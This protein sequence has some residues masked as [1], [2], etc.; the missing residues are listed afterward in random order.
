LGS[1]CSDPQALFI[2]D[3]SPLIGAGHITRCLALAR[4]LAIGG[5]HCHFAVSPNALRTVPA[6]NASGFSISVVEFQSTSLMRLCKRQARIDLLILDNYRLDVGFER[7][8]RSFART[9]LVID[10][11]TNRS[12]DCDFLVDGA[13]TESR[14]Y[15]NLVPSQTR[16]LLGPKFALIGSEFQLNRSTSLARRDG[17][18]VRELLISCGATDPVNATSRILDAVGRDASDIRVTVVLSSQAFHLDSVRQRLSKNASLILDA[19][20]MPELMTR[21][22]IAIGGA[23]G[24]AYERAALG[25]PTALFVSVENQREI[26]SLVTSQGAALYI[27]LLD[28]DFSVRLRKAF[29]RLR[30]EPEL[31]KSLALA[32]YALIDGQAALRITEILK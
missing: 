24:T 25:L 20:N 11:A 21:A 30:N 1:K 26:A 13:A 31:R 28:S 8:A 14:I 6:L 12:H 10:D 32:G 16:L 9:I 5:W 3:A 15:S 22:D 7:G 17:R 19:Q 27:G 4:G 2:C 29:D 23:G 18:P